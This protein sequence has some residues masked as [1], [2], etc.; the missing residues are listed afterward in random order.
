[1]PLVNFFLLVIVGENVG[2]T[3]VHGMMLLLFDQSLWKQTD[4]LGTLFQIPF[5]LLIGIVQI[6]C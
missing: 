5:L 4:T 3:L 1:M 6:L 2:G